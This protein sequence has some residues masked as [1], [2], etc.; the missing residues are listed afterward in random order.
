MLRISVFWN[1]NLA[2]KEKNT[3]PGLI[4]PESKDTKDKVSPYTVRSPLK[5]AAYKL[6]R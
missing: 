6:T 2:R 1:P 3:F 5:A 4:V